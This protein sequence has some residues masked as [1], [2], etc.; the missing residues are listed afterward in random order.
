VDRTPKPY[1]PGFRDMNLVLA[2]GLT[3]LF[4]VVIW[5]VVLA[6]RVVGIRRR[7]DGLDAAIAEAQGQLDALTQQLVSEA[8]FATA[9][10]QSRDLPALL[11]LLQRSDDPRLVQ[12]AVVLADLDRALDRVRTNRML[13]QAEHEQL[14]SHPVA[15]FLERILVKSQG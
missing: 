4:F 9:P 15:A 13:A 12:Q 10:V 8:A 6:A 3:F 2:F 11:N 5:L 1:Y 14:V 7:I